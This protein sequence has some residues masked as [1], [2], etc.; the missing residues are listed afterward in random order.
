MTGHRAGTETTGHLYFI[1][2]RDLALL[3]EWSSLV[4][5]YGLGH[6][7]YRGRAFA[8]RRQNRCLSSC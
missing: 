4:E 8:D 6:E 1:Y 3:N 5:R 7:H 2:I